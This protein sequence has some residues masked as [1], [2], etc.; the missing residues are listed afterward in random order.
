MIQQI[1]HIFHR[2]LR[3]SAD[4]IYFEY[5]KATWHARPL[6]DFIIIGAQKS[7]TS[8]IHDYLM[9][10]PQLFTSP[11][12]KEIH[13]FDSNVH[14]K[15]TNAHEKGEN[16]YR[17]HF[18]SHR[19]R[20][21]GSKTFDV[22]PT[23]LFHPLVPGRIFNLIPG[24]KLIALLRNPSERAISHYFMNQWKNA[25]HRPMLEAFQQEQ[26]R[27]ETVN[28]E[29]DYGNEIYGESYKLGGHYAEQLERYR[30]FFP[31]NQMLLLGSEEF[32]KDPY[33]SLHRVFDFVGVDADFKVPNLT[34]RNVGRNKTEIPHAVRRYLD[35][36]FKPYNQALYELTGQNFGW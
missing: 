15:K 4:S 29:M 6:P 35:E 28:I 26:A 22:T 10:H 1:N 9:Q 13:F 27:L 21:V 32:F 25:E 34:P 20:G 5:R 16:W 23:Y 19:E 17:A 14:Y 3:K 30:R 18:P 36:Y 12:K 24:V 2:R 11:F 7:G 33:K 31:A 8:S